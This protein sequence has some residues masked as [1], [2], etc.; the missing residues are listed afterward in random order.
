MMT[1][2]NRSID[3]GM[4]VLEVVHASG[5]VSLAVLAARTGL[6][7]PTVLRICATLEARRWLFRRSS[8]GSYQLGSAFPQGAG[9]PNLVDRLVAVGKQEL[10]RLSA[11]TGLASDLAAAIGG[12]RVE[13]VDTSRSHRLHAI[14]PDAVGFRPSPILSALGSAYLFALAAEERGRVLQEIV[15]RLPREEV[16]VL[17]QLP[18]ILKDIAARG[19][20]IRSPGHWGRAVDYGA[21]P[22]A[23]ALPI[24]AGDAPIGA[25]NL[26]WNASDHR[27]EAVAADHLAQ[28]HAAAQAIGRAYAEQVAPTS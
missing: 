12:G 14:Y 18:R 24:R 27:V 6:P 1:K 19:Y 26:I 28:L 13:I 3:R 25:I 21:L 10:L 4:S 9:M 7:K 15:E 5:K 20:A 23:I 16:K 2:L 22:A 11:A 17:P 8:D